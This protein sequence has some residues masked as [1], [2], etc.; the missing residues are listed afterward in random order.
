MAVDYTMRDPKSRPRNDKTKVVRDTLLL[1]AAHSLSF[2]RNALEIGGLATGFLCD[3]F[4][5]GG[6][7]L[8]GI[9]EPLVG[10]PQLAL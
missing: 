10:G 5:V 3:P 7:S 6:F 8:D 4:H 9:I 1:Q 2:D